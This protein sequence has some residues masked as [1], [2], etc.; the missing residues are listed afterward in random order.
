MVLTPGCGKKKAEQEDAAKKYRA[1]NPTDN[2]DAQQ[3]KTAKLF[4]KLR[5]ADQSVRQAKST[6]ETLAAHRERMKICDQLLERELLPAQKH[7]CVQSKLHAALQRIA[8]KDPGADKVRQGLDIFIAELLIDSDPELVRMAKTSLLSMEAGL[9]VSTQ[10]HSP[11][12]LI[13]LS[14]DLL[15]SFP[16][17]PRVALEL[18][19]MVQMFYRAGKNKIA[20]ALMKKLAPTLHT[21][22]LKENQV[23][24]NVFD[25]RIA[26][27]KLGFLDTIVKLAKNEDSV[28]GDF[29]AQVQQIS[30]TMKFN[31]E[32]FAEMLIALQRLEM[33]QQYEA[34]RILIGM[35]E[36]KQDQIGD[37]ELS[38]IM[39][40]QIKM[41]NKR[42]SLLNQAFAPKGLTDNGRPL[43]WA[44][45]KGKPVIVVFTTIRSQQAL[46]AIQLFEALHQQYKKHGVEMV[47]VSM[48]R[49]VAQTTEVFKNRKG[50]WQLLV[51]HSSSQKQ[52]FAEQYGIQQAPYTLLLDAEGI[53]K[54]IHL[55]IQTLDTK[56]AKQIGIS[57]PKPNPEQDKSP[58]AKPTKPQ[59]R[60]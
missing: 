26:L 7:L 16:D 22:K 45:F 27:K 21:S 3:S 53:V 39:A 25:T 31:R 57:A 20:F 36:K 49:E 2:K 58:K 43:D 34:F 5:L 42:I 8:R 29:N 15:K 46:N 54:D 18:R 1:A 32:L 30:A 17:H 28:L 40:S 47:V 4:D 6:K 35:M 59:K 41:C 24:A 37:P 52:T 33:A 60:P 55:P 56:L 23:A 12:Q 14:D 9:F 38:K 13:K 51:P 11:N 50:S 44:A 19:N 48:D 10:D